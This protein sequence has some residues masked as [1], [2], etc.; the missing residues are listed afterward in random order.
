MQTKPKE[1]SIVTSSYDAERNVITFTVKGQG[2]MT[3]DL[4][5]VSK[6]NLARAVVH[7]FNQRIP[8]AAAIGRTDADGKIIP[9][10]ERTRIKW[11]RMNELCVH[12]ESGTTEWSRKGEGGP[13]RVLTIEAIARVKGITYEDAEAIVDKHAEMH[14]MERKAALA[15][16]RKKSAKTVAMMDTI[17]DERRAAKGDQTD[18]T[19]DDLLD[20]IDC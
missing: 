19:A 15:D 12:Y 20:G 13:S 6:E 16:I 3:L 17:R 4:N 11:E 5:K 18:L 2:D 7:G 9:E 1:N 8:D 14:K 10:D